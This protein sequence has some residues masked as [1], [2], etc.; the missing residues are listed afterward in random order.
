MVFGKSHILSEGST[1]TGEELDSDGSHFL[2][3]RLSFEQN[4][5]WVCV[6][7]CVCMCECVSVSACAQTPWRDPWALGQPIPGRRRSQSQKGLELAGP[8]CRIHSTLCHLWPCSLGLNSPQN[9]WLSPGWRCLYVHVASS[10]ARTWFL[11]ERTTTCPLCPVGQWVPPLWLH[12]YSGSTCWGGHSPRLT[13]F[14]A[15]LLCGCSEN[16]SHIAL[17]MNASPAWRGH[18]PHCPWDQ[19]PSTFVSTHPGPVSFDLDKVWNCDCWAS[20]EPLPINS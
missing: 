8:W 15:C 7:V 9:T 10:K 6:C 17:D 1:A 5:V 18:C 4:I 11:Q 14:T 12:S 3:T 2:H 20:C 13:P 19:N 16:R